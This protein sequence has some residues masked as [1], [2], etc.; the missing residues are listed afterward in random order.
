MVQSPFFASY[1]PN[2]A[3]RQRMFCLPYAGGAAWIYRPWMAQ[4]ATQ[5][6]LDLC[7]IELP[8]RAARIREPLRTSLPGLVAELAEAM[9]PLLDKPYIM[10]GH[11]MGALLSF[12]VARLL[13]RQGRPLPRH[14][15]VSA[16]RA[17]HL[18]NPDPTTHLLGDSALIDKLRRLGG[19]PDEVFEQ[20]ELLAL[21]L[22]VVRA[23]FTVCDT[24]DYQEDAPFAFPITVFGGSNDAMVSREDLAR[25]DHHTTAACSVQ[26]FPGGHMFIHQEQKRVLEIIAQEI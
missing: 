16:H 4:L 9:V 15:F 11:S 8:G 20:P 18:P 12:E 22:P 17:P 13:R 7:A 10:F 14:L 3:A 2:P 24:Y 6:A 26:M 1:R 21:L 25:W 19:T 23:D 5:T